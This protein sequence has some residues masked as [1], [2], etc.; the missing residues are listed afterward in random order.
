MIS[1]SFN[2]CAVVV[3]TVVVVVAAVW[4]VTC[5]SIVKKEAFE[6]FAS[7][8]HVPCAVSASAERFLDTL[9]PAPPCAI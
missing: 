8:P 4:L 3:V 6:R 2:V 5:C 9:C 7:V 1:L